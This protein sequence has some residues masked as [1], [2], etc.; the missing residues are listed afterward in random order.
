MYSNEPNASGAARW[1]LSSTI[2]T[3]IDLHSK[4][5]ARS[6]AAKAGLF[7]P[8]IIF[9]IKSDLSLM[10]KN[11]SRDGSKSF[12]SLPA[13]ASRLVFGR[14]EYPQLRRRYLGTVEAWIPFFR[15]G[16]HTFY[17]NPSIAR[18]PFQICPSDFW[19]HL[20]H[21]PPWRSTPLHNWTQCRPRW[22]QTYINTPRVL[23]TAFWAPTCCFGR[24][25]R[26]LHLHRLSYRSP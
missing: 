23:P 18:S 24:K 12:L 11:W 8:D 25:I 13:P 19:H 26:Q 5:A 20:R 10:T 9:S 14:L 3:T 21:F 16:N 17:H 22:S 4:L 1:R 6:Q 7:L 2:F 15:K